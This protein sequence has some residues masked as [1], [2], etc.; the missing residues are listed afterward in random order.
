MTSA[1]ENFVQYSHQG[2]AL[3]FARFRCRQNPSDKDVPFVGACSHTNFAPYHTRPQRP[4][5]RIICGVNSIAGKQEKTFPSGSQISTKSFNLWIAAVNSLPQKLSKTLTGSQNFVVE[6]PNF[7][8]PRQPQMPDMKD[9]ICNR[10]ASF[11]KNFLWFR[12][13]CKTLKV[14]VQMTPAVRMLLGVQKVIGSITI[15][16]YDPDCFTAQNCLGRNS[17]SGW[18]NS[19]ETGFF[20]DNRP[21]NRTNPGLV[22]F[23]FIHVF[24]RGV[25]DFFIDFLCRILHPL[26][27]L[28]SSLGQSCGGNPNLKTFLK[29]SG[30]LIQAQVA[31]PVQIYPKA[32]QFGAKTLHGLRRNFSQNRFLAIPAEAAVIFI[33]DNFGGLVHQLSMLIMT[34]VPTSSSFPWKT[35]PH[36]LQISGK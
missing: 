6:L 20:C 4:F 22:P 3:L 7:Q 10:H 2:K 14:S 26:G 23:G 25:F 36:R 17:C 9:G 19:K 12:G 32:L 34:G 15:R 35:E 31:L 24:E 13:L 28:S 16:G 21:K 33:L 27:G 8:N 11:S 30:N 5:G 18:K 1:F 29:K